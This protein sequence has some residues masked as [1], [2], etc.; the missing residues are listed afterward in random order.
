MG[1]QRENIPDLKFDRRWK[2]LLAPG[3]F[4]QWFIYMFPSGNHGS[5]VRATRHARSPVMTYIFS[6]AF[7]LFAAGY[8]IILLAGR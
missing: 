2:W 3:L 8:I 5:I 1:W 4:F 7:Y 6:A